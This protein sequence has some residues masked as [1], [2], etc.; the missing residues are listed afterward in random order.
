MLESDRA[1][2]CNHPFECWEDKDAGDLE[3]HLRTARITFNLSVKMAKE[4]GKNF[5]PIASCFKRA[6]PPI[7]P[8]LHDILRPSP[9]PDPPLLDHLHSITITHVYTPSLRPRRFAKS[10]APVVWSVANLV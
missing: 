3:M 5:K 7:P 9:A 2:L 1:V 4:Q 6:K 10:G 8:D